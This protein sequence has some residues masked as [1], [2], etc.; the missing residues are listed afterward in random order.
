MRT[1]KIETIDCLRVDEPQI[2]AY[3]SH[4]K[5]IATNPAT[6]SNSGYCHVTA[7]LEFEQIKLE[8]LTHRR[9]EETGSWPLVKPSIRQFGLQAGAL[10]PSP[11]EE[12]CDPLSSPENRPVVLQTESDH[13]T[14]FFPQ[15][16]PSE[17]AICARD[18]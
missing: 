15:E 5:L 14:L 18:R 8:S 7:R 11:L 6:D 16:E 4:A 1:S 3:N 13:D 9:K 10:S 12:E 17:H 2:P